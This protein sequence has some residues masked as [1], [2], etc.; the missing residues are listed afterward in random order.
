MDAETTLFVVSGDSQRSGALKSLDLYLDARL[1]W[2]HCICSVWE[3]AV[4][5]DQ[6]DIGMYAIKNTLV[7]SHIFIKVTLPLEAFIA[8]V[9]KTAANIKIIRLNYDFSESCRFTYEITWKSQ[10]ANET[11]SSHR[12]WGHQN[13]DYFVHFI[14][15]LQHWLTCSTCSNINTIFESFE[16]VNISLV[17]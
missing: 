15:N 8:T 11:T 6:Y 9:Y 16:N 10:R 13:I 3:L 14:S 7:L 17:L 5:H 4:Y 2:N 12:A 1:R